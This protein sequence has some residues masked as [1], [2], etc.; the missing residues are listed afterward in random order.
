MPQ[1]SSLIMT[2]WVTSTSLRVRYPA[3]AVFR[4]VSV[5]PFREPRAEVTYSKIVNPS[6]KLD[7]VGRSTIFPRG[8]TTKPRI[9]ASCLTWSRDE[10]PT[11]A[12]IIILIGLS[13]SRPSHVL[14]ASSSVTSIQSSWVSLLLSSVVINPARK[15]SS[16]RATS[17]LASW[18]TSSL[19]SS[20]LG[21]VIPK[22]SPEIVPASKPRS[23]ILSIICTTSSVE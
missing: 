15:F 12:S 21:S 14:S 10:R 3:S 13:A 23:F 6:L 19:S 2:S 22:E 20:I 1:S 7:F 18:I 5:S 9:A 8:S 4:A 16:I 11:P 17:P